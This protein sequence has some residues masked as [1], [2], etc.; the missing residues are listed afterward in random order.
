MRA[1][2]RFGSIIGIVGT[3]LLWTGCASS[4]WQRGEAAVAVENSWTRQQECR[5]IEKEYLLSLN[6]LQRLPDD[7]FLRE[8]QA[9]LKGENEQCRLDLVRLEHEKREALLRWETSIV[10][11]QLELKSIRDA[12][13]EADARDRKHGR[14]PP[15]KE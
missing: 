15:Q 9:R 13:R 7:L 10:E 14:T 2:L 4:G 3:A 8:E 1:A 12:E 5:A 11:N 6:N